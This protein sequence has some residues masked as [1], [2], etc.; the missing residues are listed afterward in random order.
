MLRSL[1]LEPSVT[2]LVVDDNAA[3]RAL[4]QATLEDEGYR[5]LLAVDGE[6]GIAAFE[7]E[8]PGCILLDVRMPGMDGPTTC[9]RIRALP[10]GAEVPIIFVTA[11]RD[12]D[13]FDRALAAGGDD[14][15]TKPFRPNE[16][17]ARVNSALALRRM[18]AERSTLFAEL[19]QQRDQAQRLQLQKEELVA[20]VVHDL[21]NP[22]NSIMLLADLLQRDKEG[23]ERSKRAGAKIRDETRSLL[24]MITTMLDIARADAGQLAPSRQ[25]VAL[26]ALVTD[27]VGA[28]ELRAQAQRV[29]VVAEVGQPTA[30]ADRDLVRRVLENL[31]DNA[32][33]HA[34]EDSEIVVASR[35]VE[36]GVELRVCDHGPGVPVE[37]REQIFERFVG[38]GDARTNRGLGLTFCKLVVEAHGG[39]IWIEDAAP[40]AAFCLWIPD[41]D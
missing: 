11:L 22:V 13:T 33:R 38:A 1:M 23:S 26:A 20:Y 34:P 10:G 30:H 9:E 7:R 8:Q 14:Y 27:V 28:L 2:V 21:K 25:A 41:A 32:I 29:R 40:G 15:L 3:N 36:A 12:V 31:V 16:L 18:A 17:V 19:K 37:R 39:R 35:K 24:R 5:V 6:Q 4:A